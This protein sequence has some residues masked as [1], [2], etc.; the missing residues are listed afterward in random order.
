MDKS[1]NFFVVSN[2]NTDPRIITNWA[3]DYVVYDQSD[4]PDVLKLIADRADPKVIQAKHTGHNLSDYFN[5]IIENYQNLPARVAFVKGNIIGRHVTEEFWRRN[6]RNSWFTFLWTDLGFND[7][8]GTAYSLYSG[9][10]VERNNSW[11]VPHSSHRY[12]NNSNQLLDFFYEVDRFPEFNLF[13]PGACYIL[14]RQ[15]P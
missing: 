1:E 6:Y 10:F 12:F 2:Y 7:K 14:E 9:K 4:N 8:E 5:Y 13:A 3:S 15:N 11:Y